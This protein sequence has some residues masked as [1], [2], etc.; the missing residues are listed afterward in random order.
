M[1]RVEHI[2]R[3]DHDLYIRIN[4]TLLAGRY[5]EQSGTL[6]F[7]LARTVAMADQLNSVKRYDLFIA[8]MDGQLAGYCVFIPHIKGVEFYVCPRYRRKGVATELVKAVR[9]ITGMA[10]LCAQGG[11][12]GS[13]YFF[14]A[15][16]IYV[17]GD[18]R[19]E[20]YRKRLN[21][22]YWTLNSDEWV[23]LNKRA[24]KSFKLH[25][26]NLLRKANAVA[27]S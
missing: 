4:Q 7:R 23:K 13:Q 10:T 5:F 12:P 6:Q 20:D 11:F 19:L 1:I 9:K 14:E 21:S 25:L 3:S 26:Y 8:Y 24:V 16:H 22:D 18:I 27:A 17:E 2:K 15:N